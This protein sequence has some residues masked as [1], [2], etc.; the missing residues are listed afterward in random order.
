MREIL[1]LRHGVTREN[2]R[3]VYTGA[4]DVALAPEGRAALAARR[5]QYP[6]GAMYFTSGMLRARETLEALYGD[7]PHVDIVELG[8]YRFGAFEMRGH[9]ALLR[10]EPLYRAWLEPGAVDVVCPGGE[11]Q[12]MFS[13]RVW[14]GWRK[15][16]AHRW[17]GLAVLVAHGG[18]LTNLLRR[19]GYDVTT[20]PNGCGWRA[21][22]DETGAIAAA[23]VFP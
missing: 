15:L 13:E 5:D 6:A 18:V 21:E 9:E 17:D 22:L 10:E 23:E 12:R 20:P 8:E 2:Q 7:V 14:T 19:Q 11:S 3:H 4:Q 16:C 1:L